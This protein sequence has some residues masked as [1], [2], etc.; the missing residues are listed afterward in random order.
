MWRSRLSTLWDRAVGRRLVGKDSH[1]N[2]FFLQ[3][4][5]E[6]GKAARRIVEH[7]D[8]SPDS[9]SMDIEWWSW[10]H[11]RREEHDTPLPAELKRAAKAREDLAERV[12]VI[13]AE[14]AKNRLR[15]LKTTKRESTP[16]E[17]KRAALIQLASKPDIGL[18]DRPLPSQRR[19]SQSA[20]PSQE[21]N[22]EPMVSEGISCSTCQCSE[23]NRLQQCALEELTGLI[24]LSLCFV[25]IALYDVQGTGDTFKPGSWSP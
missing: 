7:P 22:A 2:N 23:K 4:S 16:A 8:G 14:D 10:L 25:V 15:G 18:S 5:S 19:S 20:Q 11:G 13:N 1:G 3:S 9:A 17:R 12:A 21:R 6:A 24:T